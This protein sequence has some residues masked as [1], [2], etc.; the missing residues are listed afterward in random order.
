[1]IIHKGDLKEIA[2]ELLDILSREK[3][4][5]NE[6]LEERVGFNHKTLK[7]NRVSIGISNYNGRTEAYCIY[8]V[9]EGAG[10]SIGIRINPEMDHNAYIIK[11]DEE[12]K[13]YYS[14]CSDNFG[15]KIQTKTVPQASI[16]RA[17]GELGRLSGL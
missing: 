13:G 14:F 16:S 8:Y 6:N 2:S 3:I 4:N 17:K 9:V 12:I 10:I 1:M 5:S 7:G 15:N 11:C